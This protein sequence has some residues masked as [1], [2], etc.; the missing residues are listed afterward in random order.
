MPVRDGLIFLDRV[1][2]CAPQRIGAAGPF[3]SAPGVIAKP[4]DAPLAE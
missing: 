1:S 3:R 2:Q 4:F